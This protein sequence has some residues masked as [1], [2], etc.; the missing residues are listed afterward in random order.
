MSGAKYLSITCYWSQ[1][2][3]MR[4]PVSKP[5]W[6]SPGRAATNGF[7]LEARKQYTIRS[8][9]PSCGAP[10]FNCQHI[11]YGSPQQLCKSSD[12]E[13]PP[14]LRT[15]KCPVQWLLAA[16]LLAFSVNTGQSQLCR[17]S[18][19]HGEGRQSQQ[20]ATAVQACAH[21]ARSTATTAWRGPYRL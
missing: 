1:L 6:L 4:P 10:F 11:T 3:G 7:T 8:K 12:D 15:L 16:L 20:L 5:H 21:Q 19:Q 14:K 17:E 2:R 13:T 18:L 9:H